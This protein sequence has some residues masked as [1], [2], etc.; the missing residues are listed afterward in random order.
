MR[1]ANNKAGCEIILLD[2]GSYQ[3]LTDEVRYNYSKVWKA[4]MMANT[5]EMEEA[6]ERLELTRNFQNL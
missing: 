2:H 3:N 1:K 4:V 6:T 5:K